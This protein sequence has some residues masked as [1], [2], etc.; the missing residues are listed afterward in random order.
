MLLL[1]PERAC[2][3]ASAAIVI[4]FVACKTTPP[5]ARVDSPTDT[6]GGRIGTPTSPG[7]ITT[8]I[9][10][11]PFAD[12][13]PM[14]SG[15]AI[16][17]APRWPDA[18]LPTSVSPHDPFAHGGDRKG[19]TTLGRRAAAPRC[20]ARDPSGDRE[21]CFSPAKPR[22][23]RFIC[24]GGLPSDDDERK[25]AVGDCDAVGPHL[26]MNLAHWCCAY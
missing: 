19:P 12:A 13:A 20:L 2:T 6:P 3:L 9:P 16:A 21:H 24:D 18:S 23:Y 10:V 7:P 11:N 25:K 17:I 8:G 1:N 22:Y 4:A 5:K 14:P 15:S 26:A